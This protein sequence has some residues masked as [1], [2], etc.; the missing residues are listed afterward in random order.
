V[1][2]GDEDD[3]AA[4]AWRLAVAVLQFRDSAVAQID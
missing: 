1:S 4:L 3:D 2:V